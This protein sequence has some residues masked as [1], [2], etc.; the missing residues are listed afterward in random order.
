MPTPRIIIAISLLAAILCSCRHKTETGTYGMETV[1][2]EQRDGYAC[3]LIEFDTEP[4]ERIRGYLLVPDRASAT[5]KVPAVVMLHDH[6]AR[7]DIGK[8]KLVRPIQAETAS[9]TVPGHIAK[10]AE[11]WAGK[12]F[13]GI[14]F[15][16]LLASEG[17]AVIVADALYWGERS[18]PEA[19]EWSR[20]TFGDTSGPERKDSLKQKIRNLKQTVYEGQR[21]VYA[22]FEDKG[23]CW[24]EKILRDDIATAGLISSMPFV[25][26]SRVHAFGFSMGAH[27]CWLLS[28]FCDRIKRGAAVC[29]MTEKQSYDSDNAS[30][31]SM[32]IPSMR[33]TM[34]FPDIARLTRPKPM[35]FINGAE[36]PL[37]PKETVRKAFNRMQ[38]EYSGCPPGTLRTYFVPGGHHCGTAVQD[39]VLQFFSD[40]AVRRK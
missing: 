30:D 17:F 27:R 39:S 1:I 32:R 16:D 36:D 22:G 3:H 10:S 4:G 15:G 7:F 23:D 38:A 18:S 8:E 29:W 28:A 24:A 6:G 2:S 35:L 5:C 13:D 34:D 9:C 31:L 26:T 19:R 20:L 33:D 11:Q 21:D 14:F 12:Y 25:D 40:I 37:F